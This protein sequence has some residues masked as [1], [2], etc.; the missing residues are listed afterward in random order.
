MRTILAQLL[1]LL[2]PGLLLAQTT[3]IPPARPLVLTNVTVIDVTGEPSKSNMTVIVEGD[4]IAAVGKTGKVRLPR[5]AQVVDASGKFLIPGLWD[6]HTHTLREE[7]V[8]TF[9]SLFIVNGVT[10]VRD[11]GMPLKNLELLKQWRKEIQEGTRTGPRIVASGATL[12]GA[13][14]QLTFTVATEAEARQAVVTLKQRGADFIKVYSLLSRPLFFAVSDEAKKQGLTFVGHV[15]VSVTAAEA[16]DAGQKS[17]EHL[18]GILESCS[19]NEAEVR[20]EVERAANNPD[21]W[22]AWGAV[23]RTTDRMYGRQAR[24][25]TYSREKCAALFARFVRNGTWQCPT[26]VMRRAL[27]LREDDSFRNDARQRY[28]PQS[29]VKGWT[30]QTDTRNLNLTAEE[31]TNRK[32]RL[33]KEAELVGEMHRAGVTILAGTDLGNPYVYPGFSLHDELALLVQAGLT[34]LEALQTA[35]INPARFFGKEKE[36]GTIEKGK[37][38]DLVLLEANPLETIGNTQKIAAVVVNGRYL[39]KESLQR[40]LVDVEAMANKK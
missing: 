4:R 8:E 1:I 14:P 15:P 13:R 21:T 9:F 19:A 34:P 16:S 24:E 40:M 6:M 30:G 11:M 10:G 5:N 32:I 35:T 26:L 2:L 22:S 38:A 29:E 36:F 17:M 28:I 37:L 20:K 25:K 3:T 31:I 18:Y 12:G 7:R 23:V 39:P 27:A 33:E